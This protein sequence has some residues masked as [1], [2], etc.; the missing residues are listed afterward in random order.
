M[1]DMSGAQPAAS[2]GVGS[3]VTESF[4][5]LFSNLVKVIIIGFVPSLIG[6]LL[7]G[8]LVGFDVALGTSSGDIPTSGSFVANILSAIVNMLVYSITTALLVQLAYDAKLNR[9]IEVG[10][11]LGPALSAIVPLAILSVVVGILATIGFLFVIVPGLWI[12]GVFAVVAPVVVIE[13]AGFG[14][15][16]RS[17]TLTKEYR[18]PIVGALVLAIICS[19]IINIVAV[20]LIAIVGSLGGT[21]GVIIAVILFAAISTIGAGFV[22]IVIALLYAR[23]REI[24]EGISVDQIVS[25]FD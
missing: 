10:R 22:S 18:W 4:S 13:R 23:L 15:L 19:M 21:F 9:S 6:F 11:Y 12:A 2:L 24:K 1:S 14:G 17:A 8:A 3:L 20:L 5:I 7:S 25:V 16:G